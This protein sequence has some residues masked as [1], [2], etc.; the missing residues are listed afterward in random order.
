MNIQLHNTRW[1]IVI[2]GLLTACGGKEEKKGEVLRP[3][4]Y[5]VVGTADAQR[6]RTFSG[7][8]KAGD[9]IELSFRS[10]GILAESN[11]KVGQS[12]KK[13]DLIARLDNI[14]ANLAYEKSVSA[15]KAA[16]SSMNTAK[17][18][19]DRIKALY[20]K[21]GVSLSD[22]QTAKNSYQTALDQFESAKRNKSI[23]QTQVSYGFIYAPSDGIIA[24]K[25]G[26]INETISSGQVVAV[27]NAGGDVN[28]E[29]GIPEN[30]INK[31]QLGMTTDVDLS[32]L[33]TK[34]EGNVIEVSPI[35]DPSSAT[36]PVKVGI[37]NPSAEIKPG[38]AANVTFNFKS[39]DSA[40]GDALIIPLKAVGE[41]GD[42]N[43]VFVIESEDDKT[44]VVKKQII[45]VGELTPDGFKVESGLTGGEKIATAG[46]QTLLDGQKVR[47]Q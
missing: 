23:Q 41:D 25:S 37:I 8:A 33:E 11:V 34:F 19:L 40:E 20:E 5:Q 7:T 31:V 21:Q 3:V 12:V 44:G 46:L 39:A 16:E 22:Y 36:Y 35:V 47:L 1:F 28:I 29:V 6:V 24:D 42:G 2:L 27:L 9:E 26:G 15:L 38:M 43:F 17:T 45:E 10:S 13:G 4:R 18:E 30:V 14:E 32:A